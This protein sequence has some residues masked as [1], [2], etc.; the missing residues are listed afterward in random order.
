MGTV[1][2]GLV[3]GGGWVGGT[4]V[5]GSVVGCWC[6][7]VGKALVS[8]R[9]SMAWWRTCWWV[10][11]R[12]LVVGDLSVVGGFLIHHLIEYVFQTKQKT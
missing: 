9:W 4:L 3:V 1:L 11:G 6:W 10:G 2:G 8:D 7:S 5:G 12:L